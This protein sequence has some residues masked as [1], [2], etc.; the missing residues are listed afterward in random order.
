MT[1]GQRMS[2]AIAQ[3]GRTADPPV[4]PVQ[5]R[6]DAPFPACQTPLA[7]KAAPSSMMVAVPVPPFQHSP[8]LGM[9]QPIQPYPTLTPLL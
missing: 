9:G 1:H 8:M 3:S 7:K 6:C 4:L 5:H 2:K